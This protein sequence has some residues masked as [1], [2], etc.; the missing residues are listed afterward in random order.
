MRPY[1]VGESQFR[2]ASVYGLWKRAWCRR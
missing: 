1:G 2:S